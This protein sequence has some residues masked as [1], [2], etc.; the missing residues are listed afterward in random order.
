MLNE[1]QTYVPQEL[2]S[3]CAAGMLAGALT[4]PLDVI[5]TRLQT[6]HRPRKEAFV[7]ASVQ[8]SRRSLLWTVSVSLYTQQ[9]P[10][11]FLRGLGPRVLWTGSQ[12]MLMFVLYE[13]F[14]QFLSSLN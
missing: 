10:R 9:G 5:K 12:S 4:T 1:R 3:G 7:A 14:V 8:S 11:A 13:Q 6:Q 2:I